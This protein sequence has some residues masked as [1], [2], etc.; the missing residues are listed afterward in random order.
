MTVTSNARLNDVDLDAVGTLVQAIHDDPDQARTTWAAHVHV[1]GRL[2]V[3]V[4][5]A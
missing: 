5:G 3:R 4:A 1:E 2:R